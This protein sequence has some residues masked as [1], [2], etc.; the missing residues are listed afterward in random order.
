MDVL[1]V[2]MP[3]GPIDTPSLALSQF[4]ASLT[5]A[6][7]SAS[8]RYFSIDFAHRVGVDDYCYI[9]DGNP[10]TVD[11]VGEWIFSHAL[12][13][14]NPATS[15]YPLE[16]LMRRANGYE[17]ALGQTPRDGFV[18]RALQMAVAARTFIEWCADEILAAP[19]RIVAL[20]STFQQ[21]TASLALMR[22]LKAKRPQLTV[23]IGGAN[24]EG[25]MGFETFRSFPFVDIVVSGEGDL[26]VDLGS[27][28][29]AICVL[30]RCRKGN[31]RI[32]GAPTRTPTL[33]HFPVPN[34]IRP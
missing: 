28:D 21:H 11:L 4:A 16:I 26:A 6:S 13:D 17:P 23:M 24:C 15:D 2:H 30:V 20:T 29:G 10:A 8:V 3:F 18:H 33:A 22:C 5:A 14:T 19:P 31:Q 27:G 34:P 25:P 9:A 12:N 1:L 7:L 32:R